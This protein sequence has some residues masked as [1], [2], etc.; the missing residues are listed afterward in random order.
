[1]RPY[2]HYDG[3]TLMEVHCKGDCPAILLKRR[4]PAQNLRVDK[5]NDYGELVLE[6]RNGDGQLSKHETAMCRAC[7]ERLRSGGAR[8]GEL[9]TIYAQD[10]FQW[11]ESTI[12][13]G[14][15]R[16]ESEMMAAKFA[17]RVPLRAL[18]EAGRGETWMG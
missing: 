10:V 14:K 18:P 4:G 17:D 8:F 13:S 9:E 5:T 12:V 11:I 3:K 2:I 16:A 6:M 1:M 7:R 15:S